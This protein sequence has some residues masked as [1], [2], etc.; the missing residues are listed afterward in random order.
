MEAQVNEERQFQYA[1]K[2]NINNPSLVSWVPEE[3]PGGGLPYIKKGGDAR[4]EISNEP[5]K[6][7]NL[8]VA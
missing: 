5:L 1:S 3:R 6:G 4:P 2:H 7:T 8:G